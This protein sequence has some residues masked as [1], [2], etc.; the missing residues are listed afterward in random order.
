MATHTAPVTVEEFLRFPEV[1]GRKRELIDGEIVEKP[2]ALH[3]HDLVK[4]NIAE[5]LVV[6]TQR[7]RGW[8]VCVETEFR[9]DDLNDVFPDVAVVD[10]AAYYAADRSSRYPHAPYVAIE[11]VSSEKASELERKIGVYFRAGTRAVIVAYPE[12]KEILVRRPD[13]SGSMFSEGQTFRDELL[14]GLAV[15]AGEFFAGL[16]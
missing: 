2:M 14:P 10:R 4:N 3:A 12:L 1:E 9:L 6:F 8:I 5:A 11:V 13:G 7:Q 15:D 16:S